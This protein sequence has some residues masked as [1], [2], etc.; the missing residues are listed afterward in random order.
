MPRSLDAA[1]EG[2]LEEGGD[3]SGV[4]YHFPSSFSHSR[5]I[6]SIPQGQ[7]V[8]S[9]LTRRWLMTRRL[10]DAGLC[11]G[12]RGGHEKGRTQSERYRGQSRGE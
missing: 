1:G 2:S 8:N 3:L 11:I 5:P 10:T 12:A 9:C 6:A 7:Y 4:A